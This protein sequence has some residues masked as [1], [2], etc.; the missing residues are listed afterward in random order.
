[1]TSKLEWKWNHSFKIHYKKRIAHGSE[2]NLQICKWRNLYAY[3]A[4]W[5]SIF[6]V[7][8]MYSKIGMSA[9][10]V[11]IKSSHGHVNK[12]YTIRISRDGKSAAGNKLQSKWKWHLWLCIQRTHFPVYSVASLVLVEWTHWLAF[13]VAWVSSNAAGLNSILL[14]ALIDDH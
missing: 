3:F 6:I 1:M 8:E 9:F 13:W 5:K 10:Q 11:A 2:L 7:T 12:K 14:H 4:R